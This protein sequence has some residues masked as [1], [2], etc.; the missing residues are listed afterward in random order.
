VTPLSCLGKYVELIK[1]KSAGQQQHCRDNSQWLVE[2]ELSITHQ[3][4]L[5]SMKIK[6]NL[7]FQRR[8][9]I[10]YGYK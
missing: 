6:Q 10:S 9:M 4:S 3:H 8:R 7:S 2:H 1:N 5:I